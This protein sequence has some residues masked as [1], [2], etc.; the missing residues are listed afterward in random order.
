MNR[1]VWGAL[2]LSSALGLGSLW[3]VLPSAFSASALNSLRG[4]R[5]GYLGLAVGIILV[6]WGVSGWRMAL[7]VRTLDSR[8]TLWQG[9][10]THIIGTF[11]AAVSPS[12]GGNSVGISWLLTRFHVPLQRAVVV[13]VLLAVLDMSFFAL[14]VPISFLYLL[15]QGVRIPIDNA[16]AF[17]I[18]FSLAALALSYV[19]VFR[20]RYVTSF[21]KTLLRLPLLT[22]FE[23]TLS[24]FLDD[25]ELASRSFAAT[26][27]TLH[28]SLYA[29]TIAVRVL[30][31]ALLNVTL[32]AVHVDVNQGAVFALQ[33]VVHAFAFLVPT[34]GA[35]GY[36]EAAYSLLLKGS[37]NVGALSLGILLWRF[38]T[39]Y[40]YFVL[41][42]PIGGSALFRPR[43]KAPTPPG[44]A[45]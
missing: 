19:L 16:G 22:R 36:Q 34:P 14:A 42:P 40:I 39:F 6:W 43:P 44:D 37:G 33:M 4:L 29:L 24:G 2:L 28:A 21:L 25:L 35:S 41:G 32:V 3:L 27:L 38:L 5:W 8:I 9:V 15:T 45:L 20:L 11:S 23:A 10:Q 12:G 13:S 30:F 17:V 18:P 31:F 26:S 1:R 7:L